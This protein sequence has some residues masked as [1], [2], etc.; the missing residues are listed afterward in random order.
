MSAVLKTS[1]CYRNQTKVWLINDR[2]YYILFLF[3]T[4]LTSLLNIA[5]IR[6]ILLSGK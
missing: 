5:T 6:L 4:P 2:Y 3:D 1:H